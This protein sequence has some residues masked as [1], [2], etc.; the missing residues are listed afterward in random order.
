MLP[1]LFVSHGA[2]TTLF[3]DV[4]VRRFLASYAAGL[5]RPQAVIVVS[6]HWEEVTATVTGSPQPPTIHDFGN[7]GPE[8]R[9]F[10]YPA[11]GAPDLAGDIASALTEAGM[12]ARID[13]TRG[14]DHGAW[15]P[16]ALLYPEAD[17][18]VVQVSVN[19]N[20]GPGW[21]LA[22]GRALQPFRDSALVLASGNLTHN[23]HEVAWGR[24]QAPI[25]DW[26]RAFA[27]W[28]SQALAE[29]RET[30]LLDYRRR[31]PFAVRN[32]PTEE[33]LLPLFAALGAG[34]AE[35]RGRRIHESHTFGTLAMDAYSFG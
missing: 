18:P 23:L 27:D 5:P 2:P 34:G 10:D 32:H 7:F 1:S 24:A 9:R 19:P 22:L 35:A 8:L 15:V 11:A 28:M 26:A 16:L 21:H 29:G 13:A 12:P 25:T 4:P 30:D 14:L 6:A 20:G 17:I 3:D 31:A 33:H